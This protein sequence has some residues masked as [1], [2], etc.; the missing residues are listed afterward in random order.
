MASISKP[1]GQKN[2]IIQFYFNGKKYRRSLGVSNKRDALELKRLIEFKLAQGTFDPG[3][4]LSARQARVSRLSQL[5]KLWQV[6]I[7]LRKDITAATRRGYEDNARLLLEMCGDILL[8]QITPAYIKDQL[9]LEMSARYQPATINSKVSSFRTMFSFAVRQGFLS[10]NPF[11]GNVPDYSK[12]LP[13]WF[14][15]DEVRVYLDY[16]MHPDRPRWAQTY[17]VTLLNCGTRKTE[18][19]N[20]MW[21]QNVFLMEKRLKIKG[22]GRYGGKERIIPLNDAALAAFAGAQRK[23]GEERVF[24]QVSSIEAVKSA[25]RRFRKETGFSYRIHNTR[26]NYATRL[27]M[28][29]VSIQDI[30]YIMGWEDYKTAKI[31]EGFSPDFLM[32][33]RNAVNMQR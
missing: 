17:F 28:S 9:L 26:S 13:V 23:L 30:M 33:N 19:F 8:K 4:M 10:V 21:S 32:Q 24:W 18:H 15:D 27:R 6:H 22:K 25:W 31:Y 16:W 3:A 5:V 29:G 1:P 12:R 20:L 2:W 11:S 14:R 7:G